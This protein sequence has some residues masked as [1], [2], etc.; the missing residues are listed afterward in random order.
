VAGT[1]IVQDYMCGPLGWPYE[2]FKLSVLA[3]LCRVRLVFLSVGAGPIHHSL[4]R[5]FLKRSLGFAHYRSYRDDASKD[6]LR[7]IGFSNDADLVYPDVVFGL[8]PGNFGHG[9]RLPGKRRVVGLGLKD[10]T[11]NS[12]GTDAYRHYLETMATFVSWLQ[13]RGYDVRLLIGDFQYDTSVREELVEILRRRGEAV[14][15]PLL[16]VEAA[17][18]VSE[19]LRQLGEAEI[20][21][22]PRYHNLVMSLIQGKPVMALSDH[23]KLDSLI[24]DFGLAEYRISLEHLS[25]EELKERFCDL[26]G[27]LEQLRLH[28][29]AGVEK[30]RQALERQYAALLPG[31]GRGAKPVRLPG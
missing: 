28:V 12:L 4:A 31:D 27:N 11:T 17:P 9:R 15:P 2:I 26:Q 19:L 7:G 3:V 6:Y 23:A 29:T 10:F 5:W 16:T 8:S 14:D 30:Y 1:G 24:T 20:V 13:T 25:G 22:S 21:I 18:T